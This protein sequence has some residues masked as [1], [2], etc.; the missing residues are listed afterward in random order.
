MVASKLREFIVKS[1]LKFN[2]VAEKSGISPTVFSAIMT[3]T[4][5]LS[6]DEFFAICDALEVAPDL[7]HPTDKTA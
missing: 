2:F 7:F 5:K 4:R 3:G 6:A 1:G